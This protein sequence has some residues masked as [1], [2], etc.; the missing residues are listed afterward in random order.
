MGNSTP[1]LKSPKTSKKYILIIIV[2]AVIFGT[3]FLLWQYGWLVEDI[4]ILQVLIHSSCKTRHDAIEKDF[5]ESNF[6]ETDEDCKVVSLG[7]PY[8]EFGCYKFVNKSVDENVLLEKVEAYN[9]KCAGPIDKCALA[10]EAKCV[11][12]KCVPIEEIDET[13]DWKTFRNE[14]LGFEF[15]YL[16]DVTII[17]R[18]PDVWG[19]DIKN[20]SSSFPVDWS[21]IKGENQ[22]NKTAQDYANFAGG[23]GLKSKI[24]DNCIVDG[25]EGKRVLLEFYSNGEFSL[26]NKFIQIFI[27]KGDFVYTFNC[28]NRISDKEYDC[29]HFN[30]MLST[31]RFLE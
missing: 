10:P 21:I 18:L 1:L 4:P 15:N 24:I 25:I 26:T 13:A 2:I 17:T 14:E 27:V 28:A 31:F 5:E 11:S 22:L 9:K 23:T 12:K 6:C 7:G 16:K 20:P 3:G 8:F 29:D 19:V 30:Q